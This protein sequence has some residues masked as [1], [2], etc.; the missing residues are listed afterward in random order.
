[1]QM[2]LLVDG[3]VFIKRG[4]QGTAKNFLHTVSSVVIPNFIAK[5]F[6]NLKFIKKSNQINSI[7]LQTLRYILQ[8]FDT[9]GSAWATD[10][11]ELGIFL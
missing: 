4:Q 9:N 6:S 2:L 3:D 7:Y 8:V 5:H 11:P 10:G 1:M